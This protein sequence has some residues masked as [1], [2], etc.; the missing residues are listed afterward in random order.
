M[1]HLE[2]D[3]K[4]LSQRLVEM[5]MTE[6]ERINNV[7]QICSEMMRNAQSMERAA[8][9]ESSGRQ[10][11]GKFFGKPGGASGVRQG[12]NKVSPSLLTESRLGSLRAATLFRFGVFF[13]P[14]FKSFLIDLMG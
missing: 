7:N 9:A 5:K 14:L 10:V 12:M 4:D 13:Q 11:L 6:M 2:A 8:A 1:E 3:N